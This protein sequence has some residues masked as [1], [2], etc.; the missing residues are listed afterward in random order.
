MTPTARV[1]GSAL[2]GV[3]GLFLAVV[4]RRPEPAVAAAPFLTMGV[5]GFAALRPPRVTA[6]LEVGP[7]RLV[8]GDQVEVVV[9]LESVGAGRVQLALDLPPGLRG[10]DLDLATEL[11]VGS[12]RRA[13]TRWTLVAPDWGATGQVRLDIAAT[14]VVGAWVRRAQ[15]W[16]P[17]V[18]VLPSETRLRSV[19]GPR[20]LR[21]ISG[22]HLSRQRGDGI[23]FV[24]SRAFAPG[25]RARDVNW[26]VSARRD[27]LWVDE[28]RPERSG[29]V[30]VFLDTFVS[31]GD[32]AD[33]SLRR[34]VEVAR[35][36]AARHLGANDR[37][38][39]VDLGG[40]LR[41]VRPTGGTVQLY[42][43]AETLV[44]TETWAS[45]AD[46]TVDV[47]PAR[48]LPRRCLVVAVSPLVDPRGVEALRTLRARG[49][50][51]AVVE[52]SPISFVAPAS[53]AR[54]RLAQ[55]LWQLERAAV[56]HQLRHE[57][58]AVGVWQPDQPLDPVL[59]SIGVFR[60]AV[61]RS[62]R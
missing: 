48:A 3:V 39:L 20:S 25:D 22:A 28:R 7:Q 8:E 57:G 49:F 38:G 10:V 36:L 31:V 13:T 33:N 51:V 21:S 55:R 56:R 26:R 50:D 60:T 43:I 14:D 44:E 53:G 19:V 61:L 54:T 32:T 27:E 42:R 58:I 23:E 2:V 30:V 34:S 46:K 17:V 29:E 35:A 41:W 40:V 5:V 52:V 9:H 59:D 47:L 24:D 1:V 16:S 11:L 12:G 45:G 15:L 4:A 62:A 18:K 37:V 6:T